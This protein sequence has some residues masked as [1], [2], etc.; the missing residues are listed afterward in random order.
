[1]ITNNYHKEVINLSK[2]D[3]HTEQIRELYNQADSVWP[4]KDPWHS[5][6]KQVIESKIYEWANTKD[7]DLILNAGSGGTFYNIKGTM[8]HLDIADNKINCFDNYIVGS[9]EDIPDESKKYDYVICVGSVLNYTQI[10]PSLNEL[11]RVLKPGGYLIVEFERTNSA[12]LW[13]TKGYGKNCV[14]K[15]YNY[16][17]QEHGLWLYS[18]KFI[19]QT[20][21][22]MGMK[23]IDK[24]RFH[25]VSSIYG[26]FSTD[27]NTITSKIKYDKFVK[28][29]NYFSA[30]NCMFLYQKPVSEV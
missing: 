14:Y 5:Y 2:F 6:T 10:I 24:F 27:I 22:V 30:H 11:C 1:M 25:S 19:L 9:I 3:K 12:G 8:V 23:N 28:K 17:S 18:E 13:F 26:R 16:N 29:I 15:K 20:L 7:S 21:E 4:E